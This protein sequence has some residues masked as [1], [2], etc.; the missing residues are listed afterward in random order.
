E[1]G[2]I[3]Q[4]SVPT[5]K[6]IH[7]PAGMMVAGK[8]GLVVTDPKTGDLYRYLNSPGHWVKI[9]GPGAAFA[10]DGSGHLYGLATNHSGVFQY[11]GNG[12]N[13]SWRQI[14][15]PAGTIYAGSFGLVATN[16]QTGNLYHYITSTNKWALIGGPGN[17]FAMDGSGHLYGVSPNQSGVY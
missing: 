15:G 4:T 13:N 6:Q 5:W 7:G 3:H 1:V 8:F 16:P 10:M 14:G 17:S 2:S 9:G 12:S 11:V